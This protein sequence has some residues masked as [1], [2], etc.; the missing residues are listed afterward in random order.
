V[1]IAQGR[2]ARE[3]WIRRPR[4]GRKRNSKKPALYLG[5][6]IGIFYAKLA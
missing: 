3:R 6:E 2:W 1:E 5:F 4:L